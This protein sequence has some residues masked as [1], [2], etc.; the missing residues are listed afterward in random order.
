MTNIT[1]GVGLLTLILLTICSCVHFRRVKALKHMLLSAKQ[2]GP[3]DIFYK[4]SVIGIRFQL[5]IGLACMLLGLYIL[6]TWTHDVHKVWTSFHSLSPPT[7]IWETPRNDI[8]VHNFIRC[9]PPCGVS[10]FCWDD[11]CNLWLMCM[12]KRHRHPVD[13]RHWLKGMRPLTH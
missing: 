7:H 3:F 9:V 6:V 1:D 12:L 8:D 10:Y 4:A 5:P 13:R 2:G 11:I